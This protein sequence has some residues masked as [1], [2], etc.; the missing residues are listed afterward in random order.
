MDGDWWWLMMTLV[1]RF[2][3]IS[4]VPKQYHCRTPSVKNQNSHPKSCLFPW[5]SYFHVPSSH[6][7]YPLDLTDPW[8]AKHVC[9][10]SQI[11]SQFA[12]GPKPWSFFLFSKGG[13][14][15]YISRPCSWRRLWI[16]HI[17]KANG[18]EFHHPLPI[19]LCFCH[20]A[21]THFFL[22]T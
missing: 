22:W 2:Y 14:W 16:K 21:S 17:Y 19:R 7:R 3:K 10:V 8:T 13:Q 4:V 11:I 1:F 20:S 6:Y 12:S 9:S 5:I 18:K 15:S